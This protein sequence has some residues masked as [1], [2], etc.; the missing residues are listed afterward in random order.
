MPQRLM[1]LTAWLGTLTAIVLLAAW[2][3]GLGAEETTIPPEAHWTPTPPAPG[4]FDSRQLAEFLLT[5]EMISTQEMVALERGE[6]A[7]QGTPASSQA[8][9][10]GVLR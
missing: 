4:S 8:L 9:A 1:K 6:K 7:S 5:K 2:P 10:H 3:S